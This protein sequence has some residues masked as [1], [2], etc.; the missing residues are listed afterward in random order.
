MFCGNRLEQNGTSKPLVSIIIPTSNSMTGTKDINRTIKS[1]INQTYQSVEVLVIDNFSS[2]DTFKVCK[3]YRIRFFRLKANRSKA[4]NYG[5]SRMLGDYA[6]FLDSDHI[7]TPKVVEDC[8]EQSIHFGAD[9]VLVPVKF[10][11]NRKSFLDCSQMRNIEYK[12]GLGKQTCLLFYSKSMIQNIRYHENVELF[13]DAIFSS[14]VLKKQP[15]V[16]RIT[17][18]IYH[19]ED[20]TIKNLILRSWNYGKK[21]RFTMAEIGFRDSA[22]FIL[23]LSALN[24]RTLTKSSKIILNDSNSLITMFHFLIYV[25]LKH[26]SF[27]ISYCLSLMERS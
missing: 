25:L 22:R 9:C 10:V 12:L 13:E 7:L 26:F 19:I 18:F 15:K 1:I 20:G 16:S 2:D 21:L 5:I 3:K 6:L 23:D 24:V 27:G 8:I 17:S 14:E 11:S 4:R